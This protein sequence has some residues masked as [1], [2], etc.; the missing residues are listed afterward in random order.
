MAS[1]VAVFLGAAIITACG[2]LME[3][4]IRLDVPPQRLAAAATVV[5]GDQLYTLP[6]ADPGDAEEDVQWGTLPERVRLDADTVKAIA[7]VPGVAKAV[8]DVSFPLVVRG[9]AQP[10]AGHG[11][12]SAELAPYTLRQGTAPAE[13]GDVV[14][15]A[16]SARKYGK[17]VGDDIEVS[18]R[19]TAEPYR[20]TGVA[21]PAGEA[22]PALFFSPADTERLAGRGGAVDAVGVLSARGTGAEELQRRIQ[23]A[24]KGKAVVALVGD[25]RGLAEFPQALPSSESLIV[26]A[27]VFGA[28]GIMVAMFVVASTLGLSVQQRQR[29]MA[30]LRAIGT[31]PGQVRRMVLGEAMAVS[32]V[33]TVV[34]CLPGFFLGGWLFDRLVGAGVVPPQVEFR[35]G[36]IPVLAGVLVSLLTALV[37]GAV[38]ARRAALTRP[39]EALA[40]AALQPY[41]KLGPVRLIS[42]VLCFVGGLVLAFVT[43]LFMSGPL[44][45]ST[46]GPAVLVWALGL[47]LLAP[48]ITKVLTEVLGRPLLAFT[49]AAGYL[50]VLNARARTLR[51]SAA[52]LPVMLATGMATA[53]IY[54][55]TT[56]VSATER[57]YTESLR[58]DAVLTSVTGGL[59]PGL[60]DGVRALPE[61]GADG[62]TAYVT[63]ALY[64][65]QPHDNWQREEGWPAQG[66]TAEGAARTL[67]LRPSA[68]S[69]AD[70]RGDTVALAEEHARAIGK[71]VGVG[72]TISVRLGDRATARLKV[73]ALFPAR[74]GAEKF[75]LPAELLAA[76]T[77]AGLPS[78]IL[79]RAAEGIDGARLT[80][81]LDRLAKGQPGVLVADRGALTA[82]H[83]ESQQAQAWVNYL[84]VGM[85]LAYTAISMVNT[86]VM[87]TARRRREF[88]LQRLTGST[89]GQVMRMMTVESVLVAVIGI[90]LGT[91]A[92]L[93]TLVPFSVAVDDTP[94][95][96][97]PLW[98]YLV[99]VGFATLLT[100]FAT[101]LPTWT[102]MRSRP[103]AAA[104]AAE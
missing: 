51:M 13:T 95:P 102:A 96:S 68:G 57:A 8:P 38:T 32:A 41:R 3:T 45:A 4:G 70:L 91:A 43:M 88:G 26:L 17:K 86:Q 18:V 90:L 52:I 30:L 89:R 31:T 50:A 76:H 5:T 74:T 66:I 79:V 73:V 49:G 71:G 14:L 77:A 58:A 53:N 47:A 12:P 40:E 55:Q 7:A 60:L 61:V 75:L 87:A 42:A 72:D 54:M 33:A 93:I 92:S 46:A 101:L 20:V 25:D 69:F 19:G 29:E 1:F 36:L 94:F 99:V 82:T 65:E 24:L 9:D 81:A 62:A 6:K 2:G 56:Q 27:A 10:L 11:W 100:I 98:I 48:G 85:I 34:G 59:A 28:M 78:Q 16:A 23:D 21:A 64:V 44:T 22:E 37:A 67:T 15:D 84:L 80:G 63:S 83:A 35:Q 104:A 103:A 39:T 97:G